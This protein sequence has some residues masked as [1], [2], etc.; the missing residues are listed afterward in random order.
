M[1]EEM[2]I[3]PN[4]GRQVTGRADKRFCCSECRTMFHNKKYRQERKE[5]HRI[6]RILKKNRS[7]I[8]RLYTNGERNIPLH[9]LYHMGFDFKYLTSFISDSDAG[10][11]CVFGCYDYTCALSSD[12]RIDIDRPEPATPR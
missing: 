8:D 9:R 2:R 10:G 5:I 7:I 6:D 11:T 12:G 1:E 3:C 4:C